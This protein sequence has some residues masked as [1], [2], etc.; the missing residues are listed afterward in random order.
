MYETSNSY[1]GRCENYRLAF[2]SESSRYLTEQSESYGR[3]SSRYKVDLSFHGNYE[4]QA[5]IKS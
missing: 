3:L 1:C 5:Y 4:D 2:D